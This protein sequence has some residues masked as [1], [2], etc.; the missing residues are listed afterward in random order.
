MIRSMTAFAREERRDQVGELVWEIRSINH[1]F[2][3]TF[4]RLPD[5]FRVLETTVRERVAARLSRGKVE[6]ALRFKPA[7]AVAAAVQLNRALA[8]RLVVAA[9]EL[10]DLLPGTPDPTAYEV[11]RWPGVI[12]TDTQDLTPAQ[13]AA[14]ELLERTLDS[15]TAARGRE[16]ARLAEL[17]AQRCQALR[18]W[19]A[20]A[21]ERMPLVIEAMRGR[22]Q[23]R[24]AEVA[25]QLEPTRLEQEMVLLAQR[26]DVDEEMDRLSTHLT[27]VER[28]LKRP[29]PAGRR[30]DF[31]MQ[32]LNREANT[33]SSKS[34]DAELTSIAVEMKVLIEQMREQVQNI[35]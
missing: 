1:R 21:R 31:L 35:E 5:E 8:E 3:E 18:G 34:A 26:L 28:V 12:E 24:L 29:E 20:R 9:R 32:E 33:L 17:I 14:T 27:E 19:V 22:L 6:C 16:G 25:E 7:P 11:L 13:A 10:S 2:L 4:V 30:L 15:L 23:A